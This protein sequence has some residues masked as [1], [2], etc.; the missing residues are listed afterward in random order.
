MLRTNPH[1]ARLFPK[2]AY[3]LVPA[4]IVTAVGVLLLSNLDKAPS[5]ASNTAVVET[6][7]NAEAV[8]TMTPHAPAA[9]A[10]DQAQDA[11]PV[12]GAAARAAVKPR[13]VAANTATPQSRK[14]PPPLPIVLIPEQAQAAA[15]TAPGS[16]N[17]VVSKLLSAKAAVQQIP[18]WAAR[19]V[20]GWF[21]EA[22]PPRPP[23]PVPI[24]DFQAS[25]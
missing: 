2:L 11:K 9:Q 14:E 13:P 3:Q 21:S 19:S 17:A 24:Q 23:A 8:F 7:I 18:Q 1:F 25:M 22:A 16:E 6:V 15:A 20:A 12:R 10:D 4:A 5:L